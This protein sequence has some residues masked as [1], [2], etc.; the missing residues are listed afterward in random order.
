[1]AILGPGQQ[2]DALR[3]PELV[4]DDHLPHRVRSG[5]EERQA[6][7]RDRDCGTAGDRE[8]SPDAEDHDREPAHHGQR[9]HAGDLDGRREPQQGT[10]GGRDRQ[11]AGAGEAARR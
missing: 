10:G 6:D 8:T 11:S 3:A 4:E 7:H 9:H 1:M 5:E 2:I